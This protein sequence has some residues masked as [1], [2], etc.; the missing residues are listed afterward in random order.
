MGQDLTPVRNWHGLRSTL[1]YFAAVWALLAVW[2]GLGFGRESPE[3]Q[4]RSPKVAKAKHAVLRNV[5]A[6]SFVAK[7]LRYSEDALGNRIPDFSY[8]GYHGA[9]APIPSVPVRVTVAPDRG[10]DRQRIQQAV[11]YVAGL[12]ADQNG[13]CGAVL[14]ER[15]EFQVDRSIRI[16][17]SGV[18]LRGSGAGA[19][20]TTIR[21]IQRDRSTAATISPWVTVPRA[22]TLS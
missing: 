3:T 9:N 8:C 18:V 7:K 21:A 13:F 5:P 6:V 19:D 22:Q 17:V 14:L 16:A 2:H 1:R 4:T 11:D 12:P 20:G 10:D 15:G